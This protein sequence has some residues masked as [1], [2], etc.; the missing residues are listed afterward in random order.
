MT[1]GIPI[2]HEVREQA[3]AA[4]A[5]KDASLDRLKALLDEA[6]GQ[7]PDAYMNALGGLI[8]AHKAV[9]EAKRR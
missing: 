3:E 5:R 6:I 2:P 7:E 8:D 1:C 9:E 4:E